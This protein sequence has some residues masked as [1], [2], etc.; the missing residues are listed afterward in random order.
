ME[1]GIGNHWHVPASI[2]TAVPKKKNWEFWAAGRAW[3]EVCAP[4]SSAQVGFWRNPGEKT[5]CGNV[6]GVDLGL[7]LGSRRR[8]RRQGTAPTAGIW[9]VCLP[10]SW[11]SGV[12]PPQHLEFGWFAY[13]TSGIRMFHLSSLWNSAVLP[14]QPVEFG[15]FTFPTSG[16]LQFHLPNIWNPAVPHLLMRAL[17][18]PAPHGNNHR[19]APADRA[20]IN[21]FIP[22]GTRGMGEL[23]VRSQPWNPWRAWQGDIPEGQ[24]HPRG[25]GTFQRDRD[26]PEDIPEEL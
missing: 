14:S 25:T 6:Q 4:Q 7:V 21:P 24:G 20:K 1:L 23:Q 13:P 8:L 10:N 19:A 16:I 2:K 3:G 9:L 22:S 11:N 17:P 26:I 15:C 18:I 12:S 5:S